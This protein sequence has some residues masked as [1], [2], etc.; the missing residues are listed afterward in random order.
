M[1]DKRIATE[2]SQQLMAAYLSLETATKIIQT[3]ASKAEFEGFRR[4][5]GRVAGGLYLL[6]EPLWRA[7]PD[8]APKGLDMS[9]PMPGRKGQ[10]PAQ[11]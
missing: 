10:P 9:P 2:V 7:Y 8:L 6:L 3:H 11:P 4:E 5:A 1:I